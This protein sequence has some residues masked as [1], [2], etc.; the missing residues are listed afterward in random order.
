[1]TLA[2]VVMVLL[3]VVS[4]DPMYFTLELY[5]TND[6][7]CGEAD[8]SATTIIWADNTCSQGTKILTISKD[9]Q[10][11]V[12]INTYYTQDCNGTATVEFSAPLN[13]CSRYLGQGAKFTAS[14]QALG[15]V[16]SGL[17]PPYK[18]TYADKS[19]TGSPAKIMAQAADCFD[20]GGDDGASSHQMCNNGTAEQC[21]YVNDNCEGD[22]SCNPLS[23]YPTNVCHDSVKFVC[24]TTD[25]PAFCPPAPTT[26]KKNNNVV[27]PS[28]AGIVAAVILIPLVIIIAAIV[29]FIVI[30]KG[31]ESSTDDSLMGGSSTTYGSA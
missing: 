15:Q 16:C 17:R 11:N 21:T 9:N 29:I 7:T 13:M 12:T 14:N 2:I 8:T 5:N 3:S 31:K 26:T 25:G 28:I 10:V 4:A 22:A 23:A 30:R 18:A 6:G 24:P 27:T 19:C 20:I 1:M